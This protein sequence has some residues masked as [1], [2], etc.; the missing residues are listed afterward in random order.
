MKKIIA[1]PNIPMLDSFE[2][3]GE[4]VK[5]PGREW[6][7]QLVLD[8][9]ILLTRSVTK[10]NEALLKNSQVKFVG[11]A[12]SGFDHVDRDYL[13]RKG[14][15]FSYCPGSNAVSV[16]E[17]VVSALLS[18]IAPEK[19][20]HGL[21]AGVIGCGQVGSRVIEKLEAVGI[22]CILNDPPLN[23][24]NDD[25]RYRPLEEALS[26]D[27]VTLHTP[28]I[29]EGK[30]PT[31]KLI[32]LQHFQQMKPDVIFINSARGFVVDETDLFV[33]MRSNPSMKTVI[34]C[35]EGEPDIDHRLLEKVSIGTPHIAGY[36]Y[37]G[38]IKATRMLHE[39]VCEFFQINSAWPVENNMNKKV[40]ELTELMDS[41][42]YLRQAVLSSYD[43]RI[44][45]KK[46]RTLL[47]LSVEASK[48]AFDDLRK[49]YAERREFDQIAF[50][51]DQHV[52][53]LADLG[54][55]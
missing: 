15:H 16:A 33:H 36:S 32:N 25:G 24:L 39:S 20:L 46:M 18:V 11:S 14:I 4:V 53:A 40:V 35:W 50:K 6:T 13:E 22:E 37:D 23:D 30:Y 19:K 48:K 52:Q 43:V 49:N 55:Q 3:M 38:K 51:T 41:H 10:V 28:L 1:D 21:T 47:K 42:A 12:T 45:D 2:L 29:Y 26:A 5:M 8:A 9:D 54:F 17:Y 44:D 31:N 7:N 34:D 27:I